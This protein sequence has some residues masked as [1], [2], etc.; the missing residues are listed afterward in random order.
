MI[1]SH[2][3]RQPEL[4]D[5]FESQ[6]S[7]IAYERL[8]KSFHAVFRHIILEKMPVAEL[9]ENFHPIIGRPTK[10]LYS[11][12]GLV[13][14]KEYHNWNDEEATDAYLFDIR[15]HY[16][17]NL[18]TGH[19]EFS[20][21]TLQRY[22]A[23]LDND[24]MVK[25]SFNDITQHLITELE[26]KVD[27]QRLDSTHVFSDMAKFGRTK[28]MGTS[29]TK[30][31]TQLKRHHKKLYENLPEIIRSR[32]SKKIDVLFAEFKNDQT[33]R[34]LLRQEVAEEMYSLIKMFD[35]NETIEN[36]N[37]FKMLIT[38]FNQ[39]CELSSDIKVTKDPEDKV[40]S[41]DPED[42]VDS[43]DPDQ[44]SVTIRKSPGGDVIQ[45]PSDPDA[46]YDGHKGQGYQIQL[47]E[48]CNPDNEVQLIVSALP[49]TAAES[50]SEAVK[51]VLDDLKEKHL[52]PELLLA[53]TLYGSDENSEDAKE[54]G[55]ILISPVPGK[56]PKNPP[57]KISPKSER[58]RVRRQIQLTDIWRNK[59]KVRAQEEGI[60]GCIKRKTGMVRLRYRGATRMFSSMVFKTLGWN[61]SQAHRSAK[62]Q[63]K[64]AHIF[65]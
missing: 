52:L 59:Y 15:I 23:L 18:R 22:Q 1:Y 45:N 38:V 17:L 43:K 3:P 5:I 26:I 27:Q 51:L 55:V 29:I 39:Q 48:T 44:M 7:T 40:D 47:T 62:I 61:I 13:L 19:V 24:E 8:K 12:A 50:D 25:K 16:A 10:E 63:Q 36:M 35:G 14:L 11:M 6:M 37:S 32:Y 34:S 57:K 9:G 49:Q 58:L 46:T 4:F 2:D 42:K 60:I 31:L 30:F 53:D 54:N 21:K 65:A 56:A 33:R 64:M 28:L 41:K 20:K